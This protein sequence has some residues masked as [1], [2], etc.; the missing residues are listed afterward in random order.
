MRFV[1]I[2]LVAITAGCA[3]RTW[4]RT[5]PP[6]ATVWV[7]DR[8]V[9]VSPV[10]Y[11]VDRREFARE[12]RY[13]IELPGYETEEGVLVKRT[14]PARIVG[15]MFSLGISLAFKPPTSFADRHNIALRLSP[16]FAVTSSGSP[17][18][19]DFTVPVMPPHSADH[20]P[21]RRPTLRTR[22]QGRPSTLKRAFAN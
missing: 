22:P 21:R 16:R 13:R 20:S 19:R 1:L 5:A 3:E 18:Q 17:A 8:M 9:G 4:I 7:N 6:G 2:V 12:Q 14:S 10:V 15:A 11:T